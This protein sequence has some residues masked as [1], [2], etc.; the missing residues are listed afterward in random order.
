MKSDYKPDEL[1][2]DQR[3]KDYHENHQAEGNNYDADLQQKTDD[4]EGPVQGDTG[5]I[6][7]GSRK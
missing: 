7:A 5:V 2:Q 4:N 6:D 1:V 3:L